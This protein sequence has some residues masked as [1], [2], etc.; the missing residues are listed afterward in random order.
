MS[1]LLPP[2]ATVQERSLTRAIQRAAE[3]PVP[4]RSVWNPDTCPAHILPW[5]AWSL[6]LDEWESDWSE[7]QKRESIRRAI[8]VQEIKGTIGAVRSALGALGVD[9]RVQEWFNQIPAG[10]PYTYRLLLESNQTPVTQAGMQQVLEVVERTK[11]L[12][13]HASEV[14]VSMLS[15]AQLY[16][17]AVVALGNEIGVRHEPRP[18]VINE[19]TIVVSD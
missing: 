14:Q 1:D 13:S 2:N 10:A 8:E 18:L 7:D 15:E 17:G 3:V 11:S 6:S 16:S 12:R 5:L 4:V 19:N 9:A